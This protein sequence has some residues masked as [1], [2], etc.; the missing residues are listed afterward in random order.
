MISKNGQEIT[1]ASCPARDAVNRILH[2][3][4]EGTNFPVLFNVF[5]EKMMGSGMKKFENGM[6]FQFLKLFDTRF[7]RL[8]NEMDTL[9]EGTRRGNISRN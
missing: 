8:E 2:L 5:Y 6:N 1:C 3:N 4:G 9:S 7:K